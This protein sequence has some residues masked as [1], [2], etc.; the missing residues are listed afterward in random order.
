LLKVRGVYDKDGGAALA[1]IRG[2]ARFVKNVDDG[3]YA[4]FLYADEQR[5]VSPA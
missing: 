1:G 5:G 3:L 4:L 2:L